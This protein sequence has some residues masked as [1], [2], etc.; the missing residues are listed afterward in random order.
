MPKT[1]GS[2][3]IIDIILRIIIYAVLIYAIIAIIDKILGHSF[4]A[5]EIALLIDAA[6]IAELLRIERSLGRMEGRAQRRP[7]R[8]R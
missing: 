1:K 3:A 7:R 6:I 8:R 4:T 2:A 5:G